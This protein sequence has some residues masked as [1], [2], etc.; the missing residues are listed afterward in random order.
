MIN[1]NEEALGKN[2]ERDADNYLKRYKGQMALLEKSPLSKVRSITPYDYYQLGKQLEA[3]E[4]YRSICEDDGTLTQLGKIPDV[5]FDVISVSY[6]TSPIGVCASIQAIPEERGTIYFKNILSQTTRGNVTDGDKLF[7][8]RAAAD[9]HP[10]EF[11]SACQ[12]RLSF[13]DTTAYGHLLYDYTVPAALRPIRPYTVVVTMTTDAG[14]LLTATDDGNGY[15]IG[16]DIQGR[17][18]YVNGGVAIELSDDPGDANTI[19]LD[20]QQDMAAATD[21]PQIYMNL[22]SDSIMA[23][24]Y[25]L[26]ET[27]GLEASYALR[28]RFGM[29]AEDELASDLIAAINAEIMNTCIYNLVNAHATWTPNVHTINWVNTAG[30]GVSYFE[31]KQS[32]KDAV[33]R[34]ENMMLGLAGRGTIS[35]MIAGRSAASIIGTLPGFTKISDGNT[36]GPHIYGTLDGITIVRVPSNAVLT[37]THVLCIYKGTSPF[38][39]AAI[40]APYMPLVVTSALPTGANPLLSQ[41]AAAVWAAQKV[42]VPNF[43]TRIV[44]T[45]FDT[46]FTV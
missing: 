9:T 7:D 36:L 13:E 23:C 24:V 39:A 6:G 35:V 3:F 1:I 11:A 28:R 46:M 40:Y 12:T 42:V 22:E 10:R 21:I 31:H 2:V 5:A 33:M 25:A 43:V 27:I 16:Y 17:V 38:E 30:A 20:F 19:Y 8:P 26:K 29:I 15:L 32:F 37:A 44:I 18:N 41:K 34:A 45:G 14:V 4:I